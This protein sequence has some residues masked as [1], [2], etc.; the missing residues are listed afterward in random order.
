M[1]EVV[2]IVLLAHKLGRQAAFA[3]ELW[4]VRNILSDVGAHDRA[5]RVSERGIEIS[6]LA[7]SDWG[8]PIVLF[9]A[10]RTARA[11]EV[12]NAQKARYG[13]DQMYSGMMGPAVD[14][15]AAAARGEFDKALDELKRA[16]AFEAGNP[17]LQLNKG[18]LLVRAGRSAEAIAA[19]DTAIANRFNAEPTAIY[20]VGRIWQA[21]ARVQTGDIAGAR[22]AYDDAFAFWKDADE[23]LPILVQARKEYAVLP[24]Q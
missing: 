3:D 15:A 23:D 13:S 7:D 19:L 22:R 16:H 11:V 14:A 17:Q 21:R 4:R 1:S 8:I 20:P 24:N 5:A 12:R 2:E 9:D 10:G 18:I 6:G